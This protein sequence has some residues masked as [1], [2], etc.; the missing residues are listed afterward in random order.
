MPSSHTKDNFPET[1]RS[2]RQQ[3][4]GPNDHL[5]LRAVDLMLYLE[6][7]SIPSLPVRVHFADQIHDLYL[8]H[9]ASLNPI[10]PRSAILPGFFILIIVLKYLY[11]LRI[12]GGQPV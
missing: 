11:V 7:L 4:D 9:L 5:C 6:T 2:T 8:E 1:S 10:S 12:S 3:Q